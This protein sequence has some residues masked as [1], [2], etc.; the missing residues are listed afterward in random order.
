MSLTAQGDPR[1][2]GEAAAVPN[3][4]TLEIQQ[5]INESSVANTVTRG[6]KLK[7]TEPNVF[8]DSAIENPED[9]YTRLMDYFRLSHIEDKSVQVTTFRLLLRGIALLWYEDLDEDDCCSLEQL[10][11]P[12]LGRFNDNSQKW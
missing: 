9:W 1:A 12:F 3:I 11:E 6:P 2:C 5:M 7:A 10:K 4:G 8:S